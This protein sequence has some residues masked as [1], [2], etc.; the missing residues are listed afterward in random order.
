MKKLLIGLLTIL[1]ANITLAQTVYIASG[2]KNQVLVYRYASSGAEGC[3]IRTVFMTN[4]P[5]GNNMGDMSVN[6][7]KNQKGEYIGLTKMIYASIPNL[8][9]VE[10][11]KSIPI[12]QYSMINSAGKPLRFNPTFQAG[13]DKNSLSTQTSVEDAID[14]LF[15]LASQKTVQVG[16]VFK[17]EKGTRIFSIKAEKLEPAEAE[18]LSKCISQLMSDGKK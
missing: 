3:G 6:V 13:E 17:A 14:F 12:S 5:K 18:A 15:D 8:N 16:I 9:N 11:T 10:T 2:A 4:V 1:T 7:F